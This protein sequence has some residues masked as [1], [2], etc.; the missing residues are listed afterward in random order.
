MEEKG[1][2]TRAEVEGRAAEIRDRL[3]GTA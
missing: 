3:K 2:L 1:V